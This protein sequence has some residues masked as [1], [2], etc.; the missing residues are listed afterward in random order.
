MQ[1]RWERAAKTCT[2]E[3]AVSVLTAPAVEREA[4]NDKRKEAGHV[5][6]A[7]ERASTILIKYDDAC[8]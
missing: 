7:M 2:R 1:T 8:D 4:L 6:R 3:V 5:K